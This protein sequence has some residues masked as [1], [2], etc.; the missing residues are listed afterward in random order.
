MA[1]SRQSKA[2][3]SKIFKAFKAK[4]LSIQV[5]A[6]RSLERCIYVDEGLDFDVRL[7]E[8]LQDIL[9]KIE[10]RE[11]VTSVINMEVITCY[12]Q[13]VSL[14]INNPDS[15][16]IF[17]AFACPR[18]DFDEKQRIYRVT[19]NPPYQLHGPASSKA[20]MY[21]ERYILVLQRLLHSGKFALRTSMSSENRNTEVIEL[22]TIESLLGDTGTRA[23]LG[24][25]TQPQ[26]GVWFLE[27]KDSS[28]PIDLSKAVPTSWSNVIFTQG[29]IVLVEGVLSG[30]VF[31]VHL[32]DAP[33]PVER[34]CALLDMNII[35]SFG[36]TRQM[37]TSQERAM[38]L[39]KD[40]A[41][42][43]ISEIHLD[44]QHVVEKLSEAFAGYDDWATGE[45]I[46]PTFILIGSFVSKDFTVSGGRDAHALAFSTLADTIA[47]YPNLAANASFIIC[48]GPSDAGLSATVP[49]RPIPSSFQEIVRKKVKNISFVSNPHRIRFHTQEIVIFRED[50]L[51]KMLRNTV[52]PTVESK[53]MSETFNHVAKTI[54]CQGHLLPL[55][56]ESRPVYWELDF[57]LRLNPLPNLLV[58][59]DRVDSYKFEFSDSTAVSPGSFSSDASFIVYYPAE[60]EEKIQFCKI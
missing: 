7:Q 55:P 3:Q 47:A 1:D 6:S 13:D 33:Q 45:G 9:Q 21:R 23:M 39:S 14:G 34:D 29:S 43:I 22:S 36:S 53:E 38:A 37:H 8:I 58:L 28:I 4:G 50:I 17:D 18:L 48:P 32:I 20:A 56:L 31:H 26:E 40:A 42:I 15:T 41:F 54:F 35:D 51:R 46:P 10:R 19:K 27:D 25:I 11:I 52:I 49:R 30:G 60:E 24:F 2:N 44:K 16:E 59:A 12:D 57:T 5:D